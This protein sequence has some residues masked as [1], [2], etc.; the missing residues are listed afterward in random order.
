MKK[1]FLKCVMT[2]NLGDDLLIETLCK[3]YNNILFETIIESNKNKLKLEN[4][5]IH[6]INKIFYRIIRKICLKAKRNRSII[7]DYYIKNNDAI[8]TIG[9]SIFME[10]KEYKITR[11]SMGLK[12]YN[13]LNKPYYIVGANIGPVYSKEYIEDLKNNVLISCE[14]VCL[15][16]SVS[17]NYV[18]DLKNTRFAPDII[19]GYDVE[20][21]KNNRT[22]KKI[23]ISIININKKASQIKNPNQV[24]Y[25]KTI[26]E[27]ARYYLE[28]NYSIDFVSFCNEEGD[29]EAIQNILQQMPNSNKANVLCYSGNIDEILRAMSESEIVI[30]TRFHANVLGFLMN[31]KVIPICYNDKTINMLH[32][33]NF[34]GI[35]IDINDQKKFKIE[36]LDSLGRKN[37]L[38]VKK[39]IELSK[40]HFKVLDNLLSEEK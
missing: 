37:I 20:K 10:N 1:V 22:E 36:Q 21:Y 7:D 8:I 4:L 26:I 34:K 30:G 13:N 25:E 35:Y 14:D 5:K 6:R 12:W 3:R 33:L 32:D 28:K 9:G 11:K 40:S 38:K 19:F 18:A 29:Y 16:D 31:K 17:Y 23:F 15:R 2:N 27:I 39:A 24:K